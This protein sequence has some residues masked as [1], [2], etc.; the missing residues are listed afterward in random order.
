MEDRFKKELYEGQKVLYIKSALKGTACYI[1]EVVGF[2]KLMVRIR[3]KE[4]ETCVCNTSLASLE[5]LKTLP[6][7]AKI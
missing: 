2:T 5:A 4:R 6:V 1:A 3:L 7:G